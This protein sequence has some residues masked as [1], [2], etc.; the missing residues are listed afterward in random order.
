MRNDPTVALELAEIGASAWPVR[1]RAAALLGVL[2]RV[3][4]F[5]SA[6]IALADLPYT[7]FTPLACAD[8]DGAILEHFRG[9]VTAQDIERTGLNR[10]RPP[11][12]RSDLPY[13][14]EELATWADHPLPAGYNEG[15]GVS[16]FGPGGRYVGH[17]GLLYSSREPPSAGMRHMLARLTPSLADA[18]D[19]MRSLTTTARLV[20]GATAGVA[21]RDDGATDSLPGWER[22]PLLEARSPALVAARAAISGGCLHRAFLWPLGG[23]HAPAGHVRITALAVAEDVPAPLIGMVLTSPPGNL[24]GLTPRELEI[25]GFLVDG[26]SNGEIARRLVV[27]QRTVAAHVEHILIKLSARTRTL[28]AVRAEREGLYVPRPP[29]T[30]PGRP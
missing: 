28:A 30:Q 11:L 9:P 1:H 21:L 16:L 2:R 7:C 23:A 10:P 3:V 29:A 13:P 8:L 25:L 17:L 4:S 12:S 22:D 5:D 15:L 19:P 20:H 14:A 24:R 26:C 6:W 18:I 27:A